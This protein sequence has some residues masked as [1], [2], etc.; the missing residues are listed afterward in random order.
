MRLFCVAGL[1]LAIGACAVD[2]SISRDDFTPV[3]VGASPQ[4][5]ASRAPVAFSEAMDWAARAER[6]RSGQR[7][8]EGMHWATMWRA[9]FDGYDFAVLEP[10]IPGTDLTLHPDLLAALEARTG[11]A[12]YGIEP[13][14][15]DGTDAQA[16]VP[17]ECN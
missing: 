13:H 4:Y 9:R 3:Q 10:E 15:L 7:V 16:V 8:G 17:L 2:D 11:C 12:V 6:L 1:C 5:L 14:V